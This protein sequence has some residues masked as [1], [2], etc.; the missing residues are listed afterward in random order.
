MENIKKN[1]LSLQLNADDFLPASNEEKQ[2]LV[3]MRESVNFWKDGLRRL[4]KNKIAMVSFVFIIA[5]A[6]F[7][8]LLPA[9]WPYSY[10]EQMKGSN[11]L[12]PFEY[13]A[14]EQARIDAGEKVFPHILGTDRMGR[15]FAVRIMM[16]TR[17]SLSV[18]LI[19]SVLVL[20]IGATYGAV[21]AFAGG[22]VD[23]IM[24]RITDILYTIPDIL[25]IILLGMALK[26]PLDKLST[27]PGFKWMQTL[28]PNM[29]SIFIIFA[30]L[31]WVGMARIVRSQILIAAGYP[32]SHPEIGLNRQEDVH[33]DGYAIQCRVTTE[34]PANNFAPDNGK[35]EAY[36]SGGGFGVRLDGGNVGTGSIISPYY[37]SLLV[38]VTSWDC[39]FPAVCRKATRAINEEHVRGVKT[40]IPFV[41]NIL[42]H[43]TFVAGKCHTKFIDETPGLFEFTESR[44]PRAQIHCQHSGQQ[45]RRQA[46]PV[47]HAALPEGTA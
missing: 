47:R 32:L 19:A 20:I 46:P 45:S 35:I 16:G 6:I 23:N 27:Q 4:K 38:K 44:D 5:I 40:N 21:A 24:M 17:V 39:T 15:D 14:S 29:I 9:V 34:D 41:T 13:S 28:G 11:N 3:I 10:S 42:T 30:L 31:Y 26:D 33:V 43:P 22:W 25:L 37:D 36:R 2:S 7:A 8:Y 12:K 1:P 18:G